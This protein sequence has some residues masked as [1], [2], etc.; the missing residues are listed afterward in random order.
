MKDP[1]KVCKTA[2]RQ[3]HQLNM[4]VMRC[5]LNR[6]EIEIDVVQVTAYMSLSSPRG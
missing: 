4:I 3:M 1:L 5:N 2:G 6:I